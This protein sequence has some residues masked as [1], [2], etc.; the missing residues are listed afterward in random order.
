ML[1]TTRSTR[2]L[3][4]ASPGVP[5]SQSLVVTCHHTT[6][7]LYGAVGRLV[8]AVMLALADI[9]LEY[10]RQREMAGIVVARTKGTHGPQNGN[11]QS[12]A[13]DV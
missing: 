6:N 2:L 8:A 11:H 12:E 1:A 3:A 5:L 13:P 4:A 7:P 9:E 10:R